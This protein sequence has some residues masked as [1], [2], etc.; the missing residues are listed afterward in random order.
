VER[1]R[2]AS[3]AAGWTL[4]GAP[5]TAPAAADPYILAYEAAALLQ[6][7]GAIGEPPR[8]VF[9]RAYAAHPAPWRAEVAEVLAGLVERGLRVGF[10][11]NSDGA[12]IEA[13]LT[14]LLGTGAL[15]DAI[16]V[17][18][19]AAKF[20]IA[21]LPVGATGPAALHRAQFERLAGAIPAE[22]VARPIYLRRGSYF[23]ALCRLWRELGAPGYAIAE[24]LVCGDIWEL[25]LAMPRALGAEVHLIRRAVPYAT[26]GYELAQLA[27]PADT[28][29]DLHG[30]VAHIDRLLS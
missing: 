30:L 9:A 5:S 4:L 20:R 17:C 10:I 24:T 29:D 16:R 25:D 12:M 19:G 2:A 27:A 6:R 18:G 21:E 23:D 8:D 28:S 26:Y 15:R 22:G 11:S 14:E 13:R 3:P 1:V 7:E